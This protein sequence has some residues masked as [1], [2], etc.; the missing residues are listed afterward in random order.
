MLA[1]SVA[2][3]PELALAARLRIH[4]VGLLL[5]PLAAITVAWVQPVDFDYWWHVETGEY[6]VR[7]QTIP[8]SDIFSFTSAGEPWVDHEWLSQVLMFAIDSTAGYA[9][10]FL[11]MFGLGVLA[12]ALTYKLLR[13]HAVGPM[14]ALM[15]SAVPASFG[16]MYWRARPS[17]FTVFFCA[18]LLV[19]LSRARDQRRSL[20]HLPV[21]MALWTNLHGG[22]VLGL[23]LMGAFALSQFADR[24]H[25]PGATP[26][27]HA[28]AVLA[29]SFAATAVNPYTY[30]MWLYPLSYFHGDN[31][32]LRLIDEWRSPDFH[33]LRNAPL[34]LALLS[35]MAVG[36]SARRFDVWRSLLIVMFGA[37]VLQSM[38]HQ[39]LF[40]L[41]WAVVVGLTLAER[42]AWLRSNSRRP[43]EP[44][45][46][47]WGIFLGGI[48]ALATVIAIAPQGVHVREPATGG[49]YQYP[50]QSAAYVAALDD[51]VHV[52][53][54]YAW[55]GYLIR[56]WYPAHQVFIDG[57][58]DVHG[59]LVGRY[60]EAEAGSGWEGLFAEYDIDLALIRPGGVLAAELRDAGWKSLVRT[61]SET[62]LASPGY[63]AAHP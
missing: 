9:A 42:H 36:A 19:E 11:A 25:V 52:F 5:V 59:A 20:W 47:N 6:I 61:P 24:R 29:V 40:A 39:P 54:D 4:T 53:N 13:E 18:Y 48:A 55:G 38:R 32:S 14:Q 1:R 17:M 44:F 58:A 16:A 41:V 37:L 56:E 63:A 60:V 35:A 51:R 10:L 22:Y 45:A 2:R 43:G 15:L 57:R 21:L 7:S 46:L 62:L 27:R 8:R 30:Q 49:S 50:V 12:W 34:A 26:W 33:Q 28:A 23:L 3:H 31:A